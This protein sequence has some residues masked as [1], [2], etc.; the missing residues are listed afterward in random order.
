MRRTVLLLVPTV[1]LAAGCTHV[2]HADGPAAPVTPSPAA[3]TTRPA[4]T[5]APTT[6]PTKSAPTKTASPTHTATVLGPS[7]LGALKL[8]MNSDA[9]QAT[10]LITGWKG[11]DPHVVETPGCGLRSHLKDARGVGVGNDGIVLAGSDNGVQVIDAY[12]GIH[13]PEGLRIGSTEAELFR[14]YPNWKNAADEN[15]RADGRGL[16]AV[17]GN[18]AARYRIVKSKGKVVELTLQLRNQVCYE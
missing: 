2:V 11:V 17:P 4:P 7:G 18:S 9:A 6:K 10:G 16:V 15:P 3:T 12:P 8:G 5:T 13:T 14:T 1:L